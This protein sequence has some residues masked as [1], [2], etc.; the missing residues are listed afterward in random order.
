MTLNL[1][2]AGNEIMNA[3]INLKNRISF[4]TF[5]SVI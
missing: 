2:L 5:E 1:F 3:R 4:I